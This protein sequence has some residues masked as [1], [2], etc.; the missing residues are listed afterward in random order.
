MTQVVEVTQKVN[1][2]PKPTRLQTSAMFKGDD[3]QFPSIDKYF[4]TKPNPFP[5]FFPIMIDST[6]L[7]FNELEEGNRCSV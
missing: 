3:R 7:F 5:S 6:S 4:D 2:F 1:G